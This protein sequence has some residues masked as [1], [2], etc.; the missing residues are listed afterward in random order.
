MQQIQKPISLVYFGQ[1]IEV[2][3]MQGVGGEMKPEKT[4]EELSREHWEW[5]E[6][7]LLEELRMKKKL[8]L[9]AF[10]HGA[11]HERERK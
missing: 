6:S 7:I 3:R 10:V 2:L 5:L 1:S 8:F 9:D 4:I 11:K